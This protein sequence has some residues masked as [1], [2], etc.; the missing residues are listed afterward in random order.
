MINL[1]L[2]DMDM[3]LMP[4]PRDMDEDSIPFQRFDRERYVIRMMQDVTLSDDWQWV[5]ALDIV[6][7][8][9]AIGVRRAECGLGCRCA[10]E[11]M[12]PSETYT[13]TDQWGEEYE[14]ATVWVC[15]TCGSD[16][17]YTDAY[18]GL[19]DASDVLTFDEEFCAKCEGETTTKE[20]TA[21]EFNADRAQS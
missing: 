15:S 6:G 8:R 1:P 11:F 16:E 17:V 3:T 10:G 4:Y 20:I 7:N 19:N 2:D 21:A 12:I 14:S 5:D 18:V 13:K 9:W